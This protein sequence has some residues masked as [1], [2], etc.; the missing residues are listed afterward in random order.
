MLLVPQ[1]RLE[2]RFFAAGLYNEKNCGNAGRSIEK[3]A[4]KDPEDGSS[5]AYTATTPEGLEAAF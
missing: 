3:W 2:F 1:N 4:S 5:Y